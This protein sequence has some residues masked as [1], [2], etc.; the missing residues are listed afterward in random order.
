MKPPKAF[1]FGNTTVIIHS[2]LAHMTNQEQKQW[3]D[4]EWKN[5]NSVLKGIAATLFNRRSSSW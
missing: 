1:K 2:P 5:G 4:R 3:F